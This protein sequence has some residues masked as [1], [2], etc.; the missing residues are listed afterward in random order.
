[1]RRAWIINQDSSSATMIDIEAG[2]SREFPTGISPYTY[3]D[4]TGFALRTFTA[5]NGFYRTVVEGCGMGATQ[6]ER[7]E[8]DAELPPRTRV[9]MRV[10]A[11]STTAGLATASWLGPFD[12]S[13]ADLTLPPG[14]VP[15][16]R[17]LEVE[18]TLVSEDERSSPAVRSVT[19]QFNCPTG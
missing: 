9:Q 15:E 17:F 12:V 4:F 5:P 13:P 1:M 18:I 19:V 3:S 16:L 6:W 14:P 10:R 11:A 8:W 7:L 2:T